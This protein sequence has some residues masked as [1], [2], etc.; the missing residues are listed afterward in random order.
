MTTPYIFPEN[1][2]ELPYLKKKTAP[3]PP[4]L[5]KEKIVEYGYRLTGSR[6]FPFSWFGN[7]SPWPHLR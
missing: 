4:P 5:P 7:Q 3:P 2:G 1:H 6:L